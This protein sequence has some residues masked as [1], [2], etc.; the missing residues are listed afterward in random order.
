MADLP[1]RPGRSS[2]GLRQLIDEEVTLR[3]S[4]NDSFAERRKT[5]ADA[6][7]QLLAKFASAPKPDDPAMQE[8]RAARDAVA[9]AREARRAEREA[10]RVAENERILMEAA[11]LAA[12]AEADERAAAEARQ[13]EANE[14]ISRVVAD[15]A[16][17]KAERDRRYAARKARQG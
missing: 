10:L 2:T 5:A 11:A 6:K 17:R 15:E 13:R 8:R 16:A 1:L 12:A 14:R 3:N 7:R 9:I 4:S